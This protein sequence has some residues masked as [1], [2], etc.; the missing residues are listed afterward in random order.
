MLAKTEVEPARCER[1]AEAEDL[2][3][4]HLVVWWGGLGDG[5]SVTDLESRG[6][7]MLVGESAGVMSCW[8]NGGG[9]GM[10]GR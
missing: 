5:E 6:V 2:D 10:D 4:G 7:G 8:G 9:S 1:V 3:A